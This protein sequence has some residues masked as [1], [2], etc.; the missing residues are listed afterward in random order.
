[1]SNNIEK[2]QLFLD[3][4]IN[5]TMVLPKVSSEIVLFYEL[6]IEEISRNKKFLCKKIENHKNISEL[7]TPSLFSERSTYVV[8]IGSAK[9]GLEVFCKVEDKSQKFFIFL[10]YALYK[11]NSFQ[12]VQLNTYDYKKDM[13][14]FVKKDD[15][16]QSLENK[17]KAEFLS[18]SYDNPHLFF[19][20]LQKSKI[21]TLVLDKFKNYGVDTILSIRKDVFKCKNDFSIKILP[22]LFNL[23]KKEVRIKKFNF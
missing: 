15:D 22:K 12:S 10:N 5:T 13:S 1:M 16:F 4:N 19:S 6:L 3:D 14:S 9:T 2:I 11:K 8:D 17:A 21:K 23:L 7:I 20:E 18:F